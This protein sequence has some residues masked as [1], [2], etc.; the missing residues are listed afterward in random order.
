MSRANARQRIAAGALKLP[1]RHANAEATTTGATAAG[2]V[3]GRVAS[4]QTEKRVEEVAGITMG[5]TGFFAAT[6]Y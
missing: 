2:K 6:A 3:R 5:T 1:S 4:S